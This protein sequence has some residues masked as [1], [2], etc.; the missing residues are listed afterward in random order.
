M[1]Q[2]H[3]LHKLINFFFGSYRDLQ[4][5]FIYIYPSLIAVHRMLHGTDTLNNLFL[6]VGDTVGEH[7]CTFFGPLTL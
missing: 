3:G 2:I 7:S 1:V 6:D 5:T 4:F